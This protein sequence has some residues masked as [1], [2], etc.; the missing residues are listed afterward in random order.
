MF[1]KVIGIIAIAEGQVTSPCTVSS[2]GSN[3]V[4]LLVIEVCWTLEANSLHS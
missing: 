2:I 4:R 1:D 3:D